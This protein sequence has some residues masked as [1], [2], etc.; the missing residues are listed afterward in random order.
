MTTFIIALFITYFIILIWKGGGWFSKESYKQEAREQALYQSKN[1]NTNFIEKAI[2]NRGY[3]PYDGLVQYKNG[4]YTTIIF[5]N[6]D[7]PITR[8]LNANSIEELQKLADPFLKKR[9]DAWVKRKN[10]QKKK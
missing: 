1:N 7:Y 2:D 10:K 5:G 8:Y 4:V 3:D 9:R 6:K